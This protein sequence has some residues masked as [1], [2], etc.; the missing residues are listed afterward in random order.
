MEQDDVALNEIKFN[1]VPLNINDRKPIREKKTNKKKT[2]QTNKQKKQSFCILKLMSLFSSSNGIQSPFLNSW[3][4]HETSTRP[5]SPVSYWNL[6]PAAE[7]F[8]ACASAQLQ[9][10]IELNNCKIQLLS[11]VSPS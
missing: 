1:W 9:S 6:L 4:I 11:S 3:T 10:N 8:C 5:R 7:L 2:K